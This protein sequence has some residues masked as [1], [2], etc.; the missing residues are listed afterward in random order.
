MCTVGTSHVMW[1][2]PSVAG[3]T[4]CVC[5]GMVLL[6]FQQEGLMQYV[7]SISNACLQ[8]YQILEVRIGLCTARSTRC[9]YIFKTI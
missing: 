5:I 6:F 3:L 4:S 7:P 9:I 8:P 1:M 2:Q